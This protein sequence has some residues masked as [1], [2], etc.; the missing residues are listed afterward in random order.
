MMS[1]NVSVAFM[2]A[3]I[4]RP[5]FLQL[6]PNIMTLK[7]ETLSCHERTAVCAFVLVS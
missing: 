7:N 4:A 1:C 3:A 5:E 2:R 6:P